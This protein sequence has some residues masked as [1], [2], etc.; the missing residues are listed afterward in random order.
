MAFQWSGMEL[1]I[2]KHKEADEKAKVLSLAP[3]RE[4]RMDQKRIR[5]YLT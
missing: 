5:E 4:A 3:M 2:S 1:H